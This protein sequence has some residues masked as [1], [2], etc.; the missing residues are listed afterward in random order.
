MREHVYSRSR[1]IL[2]PSLYESWG[3]VAVEAFA[4]GIP[5]IAHTTPGLVESMGE[6]GSS[7]T[8]TTRTPGSTP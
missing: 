3:R 7:P 5:V 8:V 1:V 6:A 4:S 2:M